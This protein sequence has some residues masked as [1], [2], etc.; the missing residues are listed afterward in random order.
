VW[1]RIKSSEHF[2][3]YFTYK[4]YLNHSDLFLLRVGLEIGKPSVRNWKY[5]PQLRGAVLG[6][7]LNKTDINVEKSSNQ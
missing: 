1:E 6:T 3:Y 2:N 4:N 7:G 5:P